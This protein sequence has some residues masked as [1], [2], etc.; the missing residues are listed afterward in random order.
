MEVNPYEANAARLADVILSE[1]HKQQASDVHIEALEHITR[2][3]LRVDGLL[4]ELFT[5]PLS[6]HN[7]LISR[8]K[9]MAG[10]DIGEQRLPQDG[11][12]RLHLEHQQLDLRLS[13]LP[14]IYGEKL[15]IRILDA[16]RELLSLN[17]LSLSP[18]NTELYHH[19]YT[20]PN[21]LVLVTGPTGSGKSTTL[22][23]TLSLLNKQEV[24]ITTLEDPVEYILEG[25][26][27]VNLNEKA[28]LNFSKGLRAL[29]RQDPDIIMVGEIRD[30]ETAELAIHAALTGHLVFST[31]H[32]NSS[33]G[34]LHR[35]LDM[36]IAPFLLAASLRGVLA[37]RLVRR[38]CPHCKIQRDLSFWEQ[39]FFTQKKIPLPNS[40][41]YG[42][43]CPH[44]NGT[45][46]HGR[47]ALQEIFPVTENVTRLLFENIRENLFRQEGERVGMRSLVQDGL[48][49]VLAGQTTLEELLRQGLIGGDAYAG[50]FN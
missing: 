10:M 13:T 11:R 31:L 1:A 3:R 47:I 5:L 49:K 4:R 16:S 22:Y 12:W 23:A 6:R 27:Q 43:G 14:G 41:A 7:S 37:Q 45:G 46:Y 20:Q 30:Q 40:L 34:A 29:V 21:G 33:I 42:K 15:A 17:Q 32:T 50:R 24:N 48:E 8:F 44:C 38:V 28:G 19:L 18:S 2:V 36:G 25:I 39:Q 26:N 9:V 35:L